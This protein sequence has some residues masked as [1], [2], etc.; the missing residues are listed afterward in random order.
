MRQAISISIIGLL[1]FVAAFGATVNAQEEAITSA[2][3]IVSRVIPVYPELARRMNL[4]GS[5]KLLVIV[6]PNGTVKSIQAVGGSP[7]LL[8]AAENSVYKFRWAPAKDESK[9]LVEMKFHPE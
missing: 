3:K 1:V 6:A 4:E 2:R 9:E 8:K 5:V 7:V